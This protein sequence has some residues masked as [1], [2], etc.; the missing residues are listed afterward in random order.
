MSTKTRITKDTLNLFG[1]DHYNYINQVFGD[2]EVRKIIHKLYKTSKNKDLVFEHGPVSEGDGFIV[3]DDSIHHYLRNTKTKEKIC[4]ATAPTQKELVQNTIRDTN[5]TLCQSYSIMTY[6]GI[7]I[8]THHTQLKKRQQKMV[9][10]YKRILANE[11]FE[12]ELITIIKNRIKGPKKKPPLW[13]EHYDAGD[14]DWKQFDVNTPEEFIAHINKT[15]DDWKS[16]GFAYFIG[17]R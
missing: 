3:S 10:M 16:F 14:D 1:L 2:E 11:K 8:E 7:P 9:D 6:L 5:D 4:S 12:P 17:K 13:K 15:L